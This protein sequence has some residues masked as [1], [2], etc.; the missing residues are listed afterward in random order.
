MT[1]TKAQL[2]K[3]VSEKLEVSA[4]ESDAILDHLLEIRKETLEA[5]KRFKFP[6]L[7]ISRLGESWRDTVGIPRLA[8]EY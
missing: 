5:A 4:T 7:G 1:M 2:A 3:T 8:K 6:D